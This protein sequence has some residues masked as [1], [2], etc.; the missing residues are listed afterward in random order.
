MELSYQ[1]YFRGGINLEQSEL[2]DYELVSLAQENNEDAINILHQKYKPLI[3]KKS[4]KIY[5][6]VSKKGIELSD[7]IQECMIGFEEAIKSFNPNDNVTFYTFCNVCMDRQ[8]N[9]EITKLNRTKHKILNEAIPI[10]S[11]NDLGEEISL[12]DFLGSDEQNPEKGLL[13]DENIKE[14]V[15]L[16]KEEL[17]SF[18]ECVFELKLQG[19]EYKEIASILDKTPKAIDNALQ[20]IRTKI[21]KILESRN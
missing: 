21:K 5:S 20:R 18:E 16:T 12:A 7:I 15:K 2:N 4:K 3:Y 6:Y 19:F 1:K 8:L 13:I 17:T 11:I 10:E 9:S 14:L